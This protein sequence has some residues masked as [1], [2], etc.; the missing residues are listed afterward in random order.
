[1][2]NILHTTNIHSPTKKHNH[3]QTHN[4]SSKPLALMAAPELRT[5]DLHNYLSLLH[6]NFRHIHSGK[7]LSKYPRSSICFSFLQTLI[8]FQSPTCHTLITT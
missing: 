5:A 1:M 8:V 2:S 4:K 6:D 7:L 3:N